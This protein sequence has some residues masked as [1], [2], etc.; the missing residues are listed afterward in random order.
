MR[1]TQKKI[2]FKIRETQ[3]QKIPYFLIVGRREAENETIAVRLRDGRDLGS[4]ALS[5]VIR[6]INENIT[7]KKLVPGGEG[8]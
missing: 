4:I 2:S 5:K 7:L 3:L 6:M 8:I 1:N